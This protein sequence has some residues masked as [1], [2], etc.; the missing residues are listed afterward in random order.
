VRRILFLAYH[1]PPI[2]GTCVQR[3]A[4]LVRVLPELGYE[5]TVVTGG[6][7][8]SAARWT[9][10]DATLLQ[11]LPSQTEVHRIEE[12]EPP[13]SVGWQDRAERWLEA[14][15]PT[16]RWWN[17]GAIA[18]GREA[19]RD[20][21]LI[22]ASL[23]PYS[24]AEAAA[25][26]ARDLRKPWVADLQDPWALDEM[27]VAP[28]GLHRRRDLARMRRLLGTASAIVMNTPE[29]ARRLRERFPELGAKPVHSITNGFDELDFAGPPPERHDNAFRIV[30]T[31]HLHTEQG[32]HLRRVAFAKRVLGGM[33]GNVDVF[34]RSLV[35][36][37][38]AIDRLIAAKPELASRIELHLA[39]TL[40][41]GDREL[42][43]RSPVVRAHGYLPHVETIALMRSADLLFLP[44]Q[45]LPPGTRAT[46]TPMKTYEYLGSRRPIL[47]GVPDG[48]A[49]DLLER[50]GNAHV[51]R[52]AD[53]AAMAAAIEQELRR[54]DAGLPPR[55]PD[56]DVLAQFERRPLFVELANV[57]DDVLGV[58]VAEAEL[59]AV[60]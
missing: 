2:G 26:L 24:T 44:M 52:P 9:P 31:G 43:D 60:N 12:P 35:F 21:D 49:R 8:G 51:C 54:V 30:H 29:A 17:D 57:F 46:I 19:G 45:D 16:L 50:A 39:G 47:A 41:P 37:L 55:E 5:F 22:H 32:Q 27:W 15:S 34:T 48:D 3:N 40:T 20:V 33:E 38:E 56:A 1:F 18:L 59:S 10:V 58:D 4:K 6:G 53:S 36:L 7:T 23:E 25:T 42:L 28:T 13:S 14:E 11:S